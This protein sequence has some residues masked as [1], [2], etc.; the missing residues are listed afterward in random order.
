MIFRGD[1]V[2]LSVEGCDILSSQLGVGNQASDFGVGW[3]EGDKLG[4]LPLYG[5]WSYVQRKHSGIESGEWTFREGR[6][7]VL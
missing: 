4:W 5:S 3:A 6:R 2:Y 1:G 7:F